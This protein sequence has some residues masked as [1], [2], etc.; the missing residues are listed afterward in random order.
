VQYR[1]QA[2]DQ[3]ALLR[4][5]T[6]RIDEANFPHRTASAASWQAAAGHHYTVAE[7][8]DEWNV[9]TDFIRELFRRE[10]DVVRW[11]RNRP[12]KRRYVTLRIP[13]GAAERVYRPAQSD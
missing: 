3:A 4:S 12:G 9:S 7:L 2:G 8:A 5:D 11:V 10:S 1:N 6:R 13:A